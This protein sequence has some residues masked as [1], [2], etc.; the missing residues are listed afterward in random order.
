M[1]FVALFSFREGQPVEKGLEAYVRRTRWQYPAGIRA[2]GDYWR[3]GA[4]RSPEMVVIFEA[5]DARAIM[6]VTDSWSD[7]FEVDV[8]PAIAAEEGIKLMV[9]SLQTAPAG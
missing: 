5:D 1:L 8:T 4:T 7:V 2:I 3:I 6:S 9:Q